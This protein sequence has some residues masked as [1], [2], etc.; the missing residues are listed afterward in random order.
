M[1]TEQQMKRCLKDITRLLKDKYADALTGEELVGF[2]ALTAW[3]VVGVAHDWPAPRR[4]LSV[5]ANP[6]RAEIRVRPCPKGTRPHPLNQQLRDDLTALLT[7]KYLD[8]F[9]AGEMAS[10]MSCLALTLAY[11]HSPGQ[12][13]VEITQRKRLV[14]IGQEE[15]E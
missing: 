9:T 10:M 4:G 12:V 6:T 14:V 7:A 8:V 15:P 13:S 5:K 3:C 2:L 11:G 1:A